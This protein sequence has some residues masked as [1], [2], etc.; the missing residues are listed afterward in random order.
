MP[1]YRFMSA[2]GDPK[3]V[4]ERFCGE[5]LIRG[6]VHEQMTLYQFKLGN[7][8]LGTIRIPRSSGDGTDN[9]NSRY[10]VKLFLV[11]NHLPLNVL[12][13]FEVDRWGPVIRKSWHE[14]V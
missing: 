14:R 3:R 10:A 11:Q 13:K 9:W 5:V 4:F 12:D 8:E 2:V 7:E 1:N 6:S